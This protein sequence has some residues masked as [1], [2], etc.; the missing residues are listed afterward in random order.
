MKFELNFLIKEPIMY[1]RDYRRVFT[2]IIKSALSAYKEG[3][4]F[5]EYYNGTTQKDF[6]W[7]V[8]FNKPKFKKDCIY[9]EGNNIK[10]IF[11]TYDRNNTGYFLIL[12][13]NKIKNKSLPLPGGNSIVLKNITQLSHKIIH[14][15]S[16][17]FSTALGAPFIVREHNKE[18]NKDTFYTSANA[19]FNE[20]MTEALKRQAI[21]GGFSEEEADSIKVKALECN[22]N[23]VFHY[24]IYVDGNIGTFEI[25]ATPEI[26][27]YFY[28]SGI[29]AHRSQ[30]FGMIE[31]VAQM[32]K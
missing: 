1:T 28:Q 4:K 2:S 11:S 30:G 32:N 8:I 21:S 27:Q 22:K 12:A 7:S 13:F 19:C 29:L 17:I 16:C 15:N 9:F 3:E 31:L 20:K 14:S 18:T 26:L 25:Q 10:M 23:V 24:G 6:T 5:E